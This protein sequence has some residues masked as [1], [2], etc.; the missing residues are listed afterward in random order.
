MSKAENGLMKTSKI[1]EV[2]TE[3]FDVGVN[4]GEKN[5]KKMNKS[6]KKNMNKSIPKRG[7]EPRPP[8]WERGIL[9][10]RPLGKS[11]KFFSIYCYEW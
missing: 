11:K 7:I 1:T 8:R 5:I 3:P 2:N 9:T 10:T 6:I 4:L